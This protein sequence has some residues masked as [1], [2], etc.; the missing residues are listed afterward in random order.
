MQ[1]LT[2]HNPSN[3][4]GMVAAAFPGEM[5]LKIGTELKLVSPNA[6][7][8]CYANLEDVWIG[9][10]GAAPA[11]LLEMAHDPL[12]R[13]FSGLMQHLVTRFVGQDA[14]KAT[15]LVFTVK[16]STLLRPTNSQ[17]QKHGR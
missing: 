10:T 15:F 7:D 6:Q 5:D 12:Q 16:E 11:L 14:N 4:S 13:T 9:S 3:L 8:L 17:I 1:T 2:I